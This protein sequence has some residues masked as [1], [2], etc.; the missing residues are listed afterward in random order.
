MVL[1]DKLTNPKQRAFLAAYMRVANVSRA[2]ELAEIDRTSHYVWK[3]EDEE[4][5]AAFE[6]AKELACEALED[7]AIRRA[8]DGVEEQVWFQGAVCGTVRK[9]SDTL[10]I[11]LL[12][13]A[14]PEKYRDNV[15]SDV[16][17]SAPGSGG[18]IVKFVEGPKEEAA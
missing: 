17:L 9:Y 16:S 15:K 5:R 14:K 10:L 4:Y 13:G 8:R 2:A 1:L 7:E 3:Q 6:A 11:F 12:K 18:L